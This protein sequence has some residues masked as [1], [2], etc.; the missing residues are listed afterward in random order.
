MKE[1][2]LEMIQEEIEYLRN[3]GLREDCISIQTLKELITKISKI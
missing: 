1:Q 2:I 3:E